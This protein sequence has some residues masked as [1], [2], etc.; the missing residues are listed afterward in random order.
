MLPR[1]R[2]A[3]AL[4]LARELLAGR[5]VGRTRQAREHA[6]RVL[7]YLVYLGLQQAQRSRQRR[8]SEVAVHVVQ[9]LAAVRLWPEAKP[10]TARK[11]FGV[12]LRRLASLGL[13]RHRGHVAD[14]RSSSGRILYDGTVV[15]V[16]LRPGQVGGFLPE[17]F[18]HPWR[19]LAA[20]L[21][22]GR[23]AKALIRA[24]EV[25]HTSTEE[26]DFKTN[27]LKDLGF[28]SP[29]RVLASVDTWETSLPP[30]PS[31]GQMRDAIVDLELVEEA[32][33]LAV[34]RVARMMAA[35]LDD[36]ASVRYFAGL[37]WRA[38]R[39]GR[40]YALAQQLERLMAEVEEGG[41]RKPGALL[42]SR[43]GKLA[44]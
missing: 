13:V 7:H 23:T 6:E 9:S 24:R 42:A 25:S 28:S 29:S 36:A 18:T 5:H 8:A 31:R 34:D 21:A 43:M 14:L 11:R 10:E 17:D 16:R 39:S 4:E 15:R 44:A 38:L 30:K 27:T 12:A 35:A 33:H 40:L 32:R 2:K 22:A 20:D 1:D 19:D 37:L 26:R 41:V 3:F